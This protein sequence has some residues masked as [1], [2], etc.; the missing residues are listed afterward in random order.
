VQSITTA[1]LDVA[2]KND[3]IANEWFSKDARR[4]LGEF[5]HL[6]AR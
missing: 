3:G 1:F 5:A 2:V 4:Y 6:Q